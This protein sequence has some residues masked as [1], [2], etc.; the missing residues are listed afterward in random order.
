MTKTTRNGYKLEK[1]SIIKFGRVRLRIRDL[2]QSKSK[3]DK[4]DHK[5]EK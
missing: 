4:T 5:I 1:G 2:D 3:V